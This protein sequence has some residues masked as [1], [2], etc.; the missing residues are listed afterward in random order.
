MNTVIDHEQDTEREHDASGLDF[1]AATH[2]GNRR[3]HNEDSCATFPD[4]GLFIVADGMGGH[5]AGEVASRIVVDHVERGVRSGEALD[6]AV[7]SAHGAVL[8]AVDKGEGPEGMGSTVV[9]VL[10]DGDSFRLA[11]AGDS[12][13]YRF[14]SSLERLTRDHSLVQEM[15]DRGQL[16]EEEARSHPERSLITR[17]MGMPDQGEMD[18]EAI[19]GRLAPGETLLLCSDGLTEELT[20]EQITELLET[21]GNTDAVAAALVDA[22]LAAGGRD[23]ITVVLVRAPRRGLG[24]RLPRAVRLL[25]AAVLG[26]A[27]AGAVGLLGY[28]LDWPWFR[29]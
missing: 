13:A 25:A 26:L 10:L 21:G 15:V 9:A 7:R 1:A 16:S 12:R 27:A 11:W 24:R 4:L 23:N 6:Q 3:P 14:G 29:G 8:E 28:L 17:A 22:A 2:T 20:D 19:D 5:E 18:V